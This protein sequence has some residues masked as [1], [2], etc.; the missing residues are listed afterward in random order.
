MMTPVLITPPAAEPLTLAEAKLWLRLDTPD[1][2]DAVNRLIAAARL[3]VE[4]ESGLKLIDQAWR[5][6]M[7]QQPAD[8]CI[9]VPLKPFKAVTAARD[10]AL[11]NTQSVVSSAAYAVDAQSLPGRIILNAAFPA[12]GR[13]YAGIEFDLSIGDGAAAANVPAPLRQAMLLLIAHWFENRGDSG[14]GAETRG[15][16]PEIALLLSNYRRWRL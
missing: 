4:A 9:R 3:T 7:D 16:P 10:F 13:A 15:V 8:N 6:V 12:P 1:E 5:L 2:D 11:D 14:A